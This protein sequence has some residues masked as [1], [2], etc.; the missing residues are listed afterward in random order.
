[1]TTLSY[2]IL[3]ASIAFVTSTCVASI[4]LPLIVNLCRRWKIYDLP[5]ERKVH[6]Q[7]IPRLGGLVF[8][9]AM[10]V[11]VVVAMSVACRFFADCYDFQLSTIVMT[12]G[13]MMIYVLG[14]FDD[15]CDIKA[16]QKFIILLVASSLLPFCNLSINNLYGL[17]GVY[18]LSAI[19]SYG[20]TILIIMLIVNAINLID[21]IDGLASGISIIL[22]G[23]FM[24]LFYHLQSLLMFVVCAGLLAALVVFFCFNVFGRVGRYKIFMGDAG[25][26]ILG[27][28]LAYLAIKYQMINDLVFEYRDDALLVS[29][30]M[31]IVPVLDLIRVAL[32]RWREHRPMFSADK[33]HIHHIFMRAGLNM[34]ATLVAILAMVVGFIALNHFLNMWNVR[35]MWIILIDIALYALILFVVSRIARL[36]EAK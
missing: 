33:R 13:A 2:Y 27:Y 31:F 4:G 7:A 10:G 34:H 36:H 21:G 17:F 18:E 26:L 16:N 12:I 23:R 5:N 3:I 8:F 32:S 22:L 15:L 20:I 24:Y 35:F 19:V 29:Y 11:A 6:N 14:I 25:S 9:P 1:M 30:T 28:V